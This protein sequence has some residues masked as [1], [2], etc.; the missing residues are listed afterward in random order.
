MA[1]VLNTQRTYEYPVTLTVYD[2]DGKEQVGS[3]KAR[4]KVLPS[5]DP[6]T[7]DRL[8]DRVLVGVTGLDVMGADDRHLVGEELLSAVK[9]DP[10]AATAIIAAYNESIVKK[11]LRPS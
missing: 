10:A 3:F 1:F 6:G 5:N 11:N 7:T 9:N 2:N 4:F 8:I